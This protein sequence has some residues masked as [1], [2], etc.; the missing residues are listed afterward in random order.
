[1]LEI[2]SPA[3]QR[4]WTYARELGVPPELH[5]ARWVE[6]TALVKKGRDPEEARGMVKKVEVLFEGEQV[7][8]VKAYV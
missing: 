3:V 8:G 5:L 1:M 4:V 7:V 6:C 2:R